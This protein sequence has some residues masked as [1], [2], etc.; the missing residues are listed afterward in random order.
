MRFVDLPGT[1]LSLSR[2]GFGT[3]GLMARLGRRESV[4]LLEVA[5][6]SGITHF[7]TARAY[8]YGEAEGALG[9]FLAGRRD[10]V[11]VTTKLGIMPPRRSRGLQGAKAAARVAA[12]AFPPVRPLL[13]RGAQ[14]MGEIGWFAPGEARASLETSLREL[15]IET[16][17]I[18]LLHECRP[19]DLETE[20]LLEF[21]QESV[22]A[23]KVRRF[24]IA[25]DGASTAAILAHRREFAGVV[26]IGWGAFDALRLPPDV[27][28]ITHSAMAPQLAPLTERA[29]SAGWDPNSIGRLLLASALRSNPDGAVLFSSTNEARIRANAALGDG[30][31]FSEEELDRFEDLAAGDL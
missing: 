6:D 19:A 18:L 13:R 12:R 23:G 7:D 30:D 24:G 20:G 25:T 22:R 29:R 8:G 31:V 4:R 21:L 15:G 5:H 17:D 10:A 26:Q 28:L 1:D 3:S 27:G 2:L 11:T 14:S 16:V 9:E